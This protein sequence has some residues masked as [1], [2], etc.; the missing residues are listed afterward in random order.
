MKFNYHA[1]AA[2][3]QFELARSI[4]LDDLFQDSLPTGTSAAG[5][6]VLIVVTAFGTLFRIAMM[7]AQTTK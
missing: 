4:G 6:G 2:I 7:K 5:S 1:V 3:Y